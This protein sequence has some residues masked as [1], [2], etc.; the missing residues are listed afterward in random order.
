MFRCS[1]PSPAPAYG[2]GENLDRLKVK[3][4]FIFQKIFGQNEHKEILISFLNAVLALEAEQKLTDIE[5]IE[6]T[7]LKKDHYH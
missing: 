3:N 1:E 5:I 2:S 7:R 6:N 4:D